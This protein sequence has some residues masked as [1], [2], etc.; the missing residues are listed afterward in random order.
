LQ[1]INVFPK[2]FINSYMK[3]LSILLVFCTCALLVSAQF[4][5]KGSIG[6]LYTQVTASNDT[7]QVFIFDGITSTT[8]ISYNGTGTVFNW[9]KYSDPTSSISNQAYISPEDATGYIFDVDGKKQYIWV[10]DY[11][12]YLPDFKSIQ[13]DLQSADPCKDLN[14]LIDA[15]IPNLSYKTISGNTFN[16]PRTF[17]LKYYTQ[18]W[19]SDKWNPDSIPLPVTLPASKIMVTAPFTN[20]EFKLTGDQ[21][22]T[23]LGITKTATSDTYKA[24]AVECHLTNVVT[25]RSEKNE[26]SKPQKGVAI[27]FSVPIDVQ[28]LSNPSSAATFYAWSIYKDGQLILNRSDKDHRYTF[29]E[30]GNYTVK[31]TVSNSTCSYSDSVKVIASDADIQV[32]RVFTPNGDGFNDEFRVAY[33]SLLGF[34][35]WVYNRWG[36]QVFY[37]N[38]PQKGWDGR[39]NGKDAAEGPYFYVIKATGY[40]SGKTTKSTRILKGDI[41]LLR[42]SQK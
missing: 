31:V 36:R 24:V 28:F 23:D 7:V 38:D 26:A 34:E 15:S 30:K 41:N 10:I 33:K 1:S 16:L 32:P 35:C 17:N 12:N 39:I 18:K 4:T 2:Y 3:K 6:K 37:W 11:K 27:D 20:T 8:E 19:S 9:Y 42:G 13:A 40:W 21:Y 5:V 29:L 14:I 22:A 25:E